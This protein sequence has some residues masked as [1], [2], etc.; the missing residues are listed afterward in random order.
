[1][2]LVALYSVLETAASLLQR[3]RCLKMRVVVVMRAEIREIKMDKKELRK[4]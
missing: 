4:K 2:L 3:L 1:M